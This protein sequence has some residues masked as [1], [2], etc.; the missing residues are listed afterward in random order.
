MVVE[1]DGALLELRG[2]GIGPGLPL[3]AVQSR[4]TAILGRNRLCLFLDAEHMGKTLGERLGNDRGV[5]LRGTCVADSTVTSDSYDARHSATGR[6]LGWPAEGPHNA[7][8]HSR[9]SN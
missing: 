3:P 6:P 7:C 9:P 1:L 2:Q 8:R 5:D 4:K